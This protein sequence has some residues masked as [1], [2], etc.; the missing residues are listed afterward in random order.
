MGSAEEK[1]LWRAPAAA[2]DAERKNARNPLSD[3]KGGVS[4][5]PIGQIQ[6]VRTG[7]EI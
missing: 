5:M 1:A 7:V 4:G 2:V 3:K 6:T